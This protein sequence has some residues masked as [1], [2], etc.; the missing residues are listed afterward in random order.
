MH[1]C[2]GPDG[3]V[4]CV[5]GGKTKKKK[6]CIPVG[7]RFEPEASMSAVGNIT[8]NKPL[9]AHLGQILTCPMSVCVC[10]H[11]GRSWRDVRMFTFS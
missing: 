2:D 9:C 10:I 1:L 8:L 7:L 5:T 6:K 11:L 4:S 3:A